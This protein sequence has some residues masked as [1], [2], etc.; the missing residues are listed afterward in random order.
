MEALGDAEHAAPG[1]L[2]ALAKLA[3]ILAL[4]FVMSV[5]FGLGLWLLTDEVD[6][7]ERPNSI[8]ACDGEHM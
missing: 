8:L 2:L 3:G 6:E 1:I 4:G 5:C 7:A